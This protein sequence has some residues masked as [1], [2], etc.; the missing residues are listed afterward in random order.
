MGDELV[1]KKLKYG[2]NMLRN[3]CMV[4]RW[5]ASLFARYQ[6]ERQHKRRERGKYLISECC[7][8]LQ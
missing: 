6:G 5:R 7:A 4:S 2:I 3:S 8:L 1:P